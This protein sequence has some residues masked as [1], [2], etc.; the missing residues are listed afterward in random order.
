[1]SNNNLNIFQ[2][3]ADYRLQE[4]VSAVHADLVFLRLPQICDTLTEMERAETRPP[5][6]VAA[7]LT[8]EQPAHQKLFSDRFGRSL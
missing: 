3:D 2:E 6:S 7:K 5:I 4:K 8:R 1:M